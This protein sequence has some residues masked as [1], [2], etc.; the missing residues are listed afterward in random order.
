MFIH[1]EPNW[2]LINL[3]ATRAC[4]Q[5]AEDGTDRPADPEPECYPSEWG[6]PLTDTMEAYLA[7]IIGSADATIA[8]NADDEEYLE[9]CYTS[10]SAK[11]AYQQ[12]GESR[13]TEPILPGEGEHLCVRIYKTTGS[14]QKVVQRDDALLTPEEVQKNWKEVMVAIKQELETWVKYGCVSRKKRRDAR[15]IID[16]KWGHQMEDRTRCPQC[17]GKPANWTCTDTTS[18]QGKAHCSWF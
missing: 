3:E 5:C 2:E 13:Q 9:L 10:Q 4:L 6:N 12:S 11:L 16:V 14:S 17:A 8:T 15:N 18:D 1:D 7:Q